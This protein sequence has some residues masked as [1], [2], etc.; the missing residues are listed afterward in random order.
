[1]SI[2]RVTKEFSFEMAHVLTGY[3]GPCREIHGHSYRLF[4]TIAGTPDEDM[5]NPKLGMVLDFGILKAIVN[6]HIVSRYDHSLVLLDNEEN[7]ELRQRLG[8]RFEKIY[9]TDFQPTCENLVVGFSEMLRGA[10]PAGI[11]LKSLRL[12]ETA[13][14]YCEWHAEDNS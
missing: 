1:M 14:S 5:N 6:E 11:E 2:V 13:T 7:R 9:L 4:V 3:D 10:M 8:R 12:H